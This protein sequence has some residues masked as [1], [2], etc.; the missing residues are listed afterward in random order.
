MTTTSL[1]QSFIA[2]HFGVR[3]GTKHTFALWGE[4]Q[5]YLAGYRKQVTLDRL[6]IQPHAPLTKYA[7]RDLR[8]ALANVLI[9]DDWP[10]GGDASPEMQAVFIGLMRDAMRRRGYR[11]PRPEARPS[12]HTA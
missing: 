12:R 9:G 7:H 10:Q 3:L 2:K 1:L 5:Q 6:L 4:C 8:N 11:V